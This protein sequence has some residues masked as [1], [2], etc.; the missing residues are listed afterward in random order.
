MNCPNCGKEMTA[1]FLQWER[2]FF[3]SMKRCKFLPDHTSGSVTFHDKSFLGFSHLPAYDC[4]ACQ[5]V[6]FDY[7]HDN[8]TFV[9]PTP[10]DESAR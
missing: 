7:S 1:G 9:Q 3:W 2:N 6:V 8:A 10:A 5:K 4:R